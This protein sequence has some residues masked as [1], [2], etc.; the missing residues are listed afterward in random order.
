MGK[1]IYVGCYIKRIQQLTVDD[2]KVPRQS[3]VL[4]D[5][6]KDSLKLC[7]V[8]QK[9]YCK[10]ILAGHRDIAFGIVEKSVTKDLQD[11]DANLAWNSL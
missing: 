1:Q 8:N 2:P 11:G 6:H 9:A 10:L 5:T 3:K 4:K 7:Q